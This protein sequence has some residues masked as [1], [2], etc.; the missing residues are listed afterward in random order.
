[1]IRGWHLGRIGD[2]KVDANDMPIAHTDFTRLRE[3]CVGGV[4]WSAYVPW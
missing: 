1:M 2:P 3:G 4:F